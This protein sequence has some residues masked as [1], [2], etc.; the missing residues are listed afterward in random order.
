MPFKRDLNRKN[1]LKVCELSGGFWRF[2][3]PETGL[4]SGR[5]LRY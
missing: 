4:L 2:R 3:L 5:Q 1:R